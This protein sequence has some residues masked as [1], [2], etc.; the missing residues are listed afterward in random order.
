MGGGIG[1]VTF[2]SPSVGRPGHQEATREALPSAPV[3]LARPTMMVELPVLSR[4]QETG[5]HTALHSQSHTK[6]SAKMLKPPPEGL[7]RS[8]DRAVR[9]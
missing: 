6:M 3:C 7:T 4:G 8:V 9:S 5:S 2:A 1:A